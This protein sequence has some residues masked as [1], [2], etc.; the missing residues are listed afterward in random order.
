MPTYLMCRIGHCKRKTT[1]DVQMFSTVSENVALTPSTQRT[2]S[3]PASTHLYTVASQSRQSEAK[4][5]PA[6]TFNET[7]L[8]PE[9]RLP[10]TTHQTNARKL[11][12]LH[13]EA[14]SC[15]GRMRAWRRYTS[16][17]LSASLSHPPPFPRPHPQ[18]PLQTQPPHIHPP[19]HKN[20]SPAP[21]LKHVNRQR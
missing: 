14:E 17:A 13:V 9:S 20:H 5:V 19:Y 10:N 3:S 18:S 12:L 15:L 4:Q 7:T 6:S 1:K 21:S 11:Q 2:A 16:H 8:R